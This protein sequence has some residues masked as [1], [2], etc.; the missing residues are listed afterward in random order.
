MV[1]LC[2]NEMGKIVKN[3]IHILSKGVKEIWTREESEYTTT[4]FN[5]LLFLLEIVE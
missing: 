2:V 5:I 3:P 1:K 4:I